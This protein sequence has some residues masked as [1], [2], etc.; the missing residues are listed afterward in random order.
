M[1]LLVAWWIEEVDRL[2]KGKI[3]IPRFRGWN[4]Q[5]W[6]KKF[7]KILGWPGRSVHLGLE[8]IYL[9]TGFIFGGKIDI[10]LLGQN[11]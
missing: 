9:L 8:R 2:N 1:L 7:Q 11:I 4:E 3:C 5:K 10:L 6:K